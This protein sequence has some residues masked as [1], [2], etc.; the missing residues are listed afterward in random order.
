M[1]GVHCIFF[2]IILTL[3]NHTCFTFNALN[4]MSFNS[5]HLTSLHSS[6]PLLFQGARFDQ[7]AGLIVES[8][9]GRMYDLLPAIHFIP[10]V[11]HKQAP[12]TYACPVYKTAVRKGSSCSV[13]DAPQSPLLLFLHSLYLPLI[14]LPSSPL[15]LRCLEHDWHVHQLCG[16]HRAA[17]SSR[18]DGA[19]M[20]PRWC[21]CAV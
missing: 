3:T 13:A 20:D 16:A 5:P 17:H 4:A 11:N 12:S 15:H 19:E 1:R 10:A 2:R 8:R 18:R 7:S 14:P 6:P 9:P 21:C